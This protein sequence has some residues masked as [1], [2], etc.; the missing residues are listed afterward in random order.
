MSVNKPI[1]VIVFIYLVAS[2]RAV[3]CENLTRKALHFLAVFLAVGFLTSFTAASFFTGF[4]APV[5]AAGS[6]AAGFV[7]VGFLAAGFLGD[8]FAFGPGIE[9]GPHWR[10]ASALNTAPPLLPCTLSTCDC[11]RG[12]NTSNTNLFSSFVNVCNFL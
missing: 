6:F 11:Y 4:F 10:E 5:L 9:P 8:F 3:L 12:K 7:S 2:K 1:L